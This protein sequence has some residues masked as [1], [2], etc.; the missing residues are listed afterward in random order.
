MDIATDP[1][2]K[3]LVKLAGDIKAGKYGSDI[4]FA[5]EKFLED[6][7]D[8]VVRPLGGEIMVD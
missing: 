3:E 4:N 8:E 2:A 5:E 7:E 6:L 1:I